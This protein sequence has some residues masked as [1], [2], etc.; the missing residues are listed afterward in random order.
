MFGSVIILVEDDPGWQFAVL[1]PEFQIILVSKQSTT[2][3]THFPLQPP[4]G[5]STVALRKLLDQQQR[6]I[7]HLSPTNF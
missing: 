6:T 5:C 3:C 4:N 7:H 2:G 1:I